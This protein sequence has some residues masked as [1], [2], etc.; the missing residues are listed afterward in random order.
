MEVV[1]V[2]YVFEDGGVEVRAGDKVSTVPL[3]IGQRLIVAVGWRDA[4]DEYDARPP[5]PGETDLHLC[6][7]CGLLGIVTENHLD[8]GVGE[9]E[10]TRVRVLNAIVDADGKT[11]N[12]GDLPAPDVGDVD[13]ERK[14]SNRLI[15]VT[16][17][18]MNAGK[19]TA[20][21]A[22]VRALTGQG[23]RVGVGKVTGTVRCSGFADVRAAGAA[24][25]ID[26]SWFG[27]PSTCQLPKD[28]LVALFRRMLVYLDARVGEGGV[29]ILELADGWD[30]PETSHLLE[31]P[32]L[33]TVKDRI[34][35]CLAGTPDPVKQVDQF[36][37]QLG[38]A[39]DVVS[40]TACADDDVRALLYDGE[41]WS[42]DA[43][44]VPD[45]PL[46][47]LLLNST[48]PHPDARAALAG[49][50]NEE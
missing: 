41:L 46:V 32:E 7:P 17:D 25:I 37:N 34:V 29:V 47:E 1:R 49:F 33:A 39:V 5:Q 23:H 44:S 3:D 12:A 20:I 18:K 27:F 4:V 36:R 16:A 45:F 50:F 48:A 42:F 19:S 35:L 43:K 13:L 28:E 15:V 11:V 24:P 21:E 14:A 30:Q 31:C 40:G 9:T 8:P 26:F 10:P 38:H 6:A 22:I 2:G